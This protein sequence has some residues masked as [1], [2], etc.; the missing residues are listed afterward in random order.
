[1]TRM[2][3]ASEL[4]EQLMECIFRLFALL[5]RGPRLPAGEPGSKV[6]G[7]PS[8]QNRILL[9]LNESDGISQRDM[10]TLLQLRPQSVSETL[11]KL[12]AGGLVERRQNSRDKRVFNIF[13]TEEGKLRAQELMIDRP[14]FASMFLSALSAKEKEQLLELLMKLTDGNDPE[15]ADLM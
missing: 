11:S 5:R 3:T 4:N 14:D 12:E 15:E 6:G 7:R 9:M 1:M 13:M 2:E 8:A 10:T